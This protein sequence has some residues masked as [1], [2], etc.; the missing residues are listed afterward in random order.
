MIARKLAEEGY[1][2]AVLLT[3][4]Q[5]K[6]EDA[7]YMLTKLDGTGVD[8]FDLTQSDAPRRLIG[9]A[10]VL[11]DAVFGIGFRGAADDA[12]SELFRW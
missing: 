9:E 11:V 7:A 12:L 4:G 1:P 8:V 2:A 10:D 6:D 3:Q 5:P